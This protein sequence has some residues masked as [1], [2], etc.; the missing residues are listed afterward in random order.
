MICPRCKNDQS[1]VKDTRKYPDTVR[2][3]R[4]CDQ[5]DHIWV[6]WEVEEKQIFVLNPSE[7]LLNSAI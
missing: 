3:V 4:E 6:T 5:C 7:K 1:S 2:R